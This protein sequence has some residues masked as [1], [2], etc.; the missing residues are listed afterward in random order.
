MLAAALRLL[1]NT[2]NV[3][4]RNPTHGQTIRTVRR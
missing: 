2:D 3:K 4:L 1:F